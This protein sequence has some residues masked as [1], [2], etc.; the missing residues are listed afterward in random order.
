MKQEALWYAFKGRTYKGDMPAFFDKNDLPYGEYIEIL[1][2]D[3]VSEWRQLYENSHFSMHPYFSTQLAK[4]RRQWQVYE[5][6]FWGEKYEER[7]AEFPSV[8]KLTNRFPEIVSVVFSKLAPHT[9]LSAHIGDTN[10]I[11]RTH[12]GVE[13]PDELPLCG[14]KV[15]EEPRAWV[16]GQAL[17]FCDAHLHTAWNNTERERVVLII[18]SIHPHFSTSQKSICRNI[19]SALAL[20]RFLERYSFSKYIPSFFK[21]ILRYM[22]LA[23]IFY[24][25]G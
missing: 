6:L 3:I 19:L 12:V 15:K 11:I 24:K 25:N 21:G 10:A 7:L 2:P 1:S 18:D 4:D 22:F 16:K 20:Q 14:I 8:Q 23:R 9:S 13:I 5:L 17:S